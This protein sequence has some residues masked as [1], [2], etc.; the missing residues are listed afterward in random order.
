M[1]YGILA[2]VFLVTSVGVFFASRAVVPPAKAPPQTQRIATPGLFK[3]ASA[4]AKKYHPEHGDH[5]KPLLRPAIVKVSSPERVGLGE[6]GRIMLTIEPDP[7]GSSKAPF[8][9]IGDR[10]APVDVRK[11]DGGVI[12]IY[13]TQVADRVTTHLYESSSDVPLSSREDKTLAVPPEGAAWTWHV[14]GSEPGTRPLEF[15]MLANY[16]YE[17]TPGHWPL[18]MMSI[19]LPVD[20]TWLQWIKYYLGQIGSLWQY[21]AGIAGGLVAVAGA[22]PIV[23]KLFPVTGGRKDA[24]DAQMF[25]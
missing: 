17:A 22:W 3:A 14:I 12:R 5:V 6:S 20:P 19:E 9:H 23:R 10:L 7:A 2:A 18:G 25:T 16:T 21:L 1:A 15:E 13:H 8:P 24:Q 11:A 4:P